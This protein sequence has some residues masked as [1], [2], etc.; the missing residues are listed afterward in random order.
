MADTSVSRHPE[1][2]VFSCCE[3]SLRSTA[4]L[5]R[6][7]AAMDVEARSLRLHGG[8]P[9]LGRRRAWWQAPPAMPR[10]SC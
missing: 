5:F 2:P 10:E 7:L 4:M 8:E 3:S 6:N 1:F 9:E